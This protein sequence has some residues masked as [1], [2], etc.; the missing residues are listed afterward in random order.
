MSCS[1]VNSAPFQAT[2]FLHEQYSGEAVQILVVKG[3]W[4][5]SSGHFTP[6]H[7]QAPINV[8]DETVKLE[9]LDLEP[10]QRQAIAGREADTWLRYESDLIPP[11]PRF[12]L[13]INA[14]VQNRNQ[15][16]LKMPFTVN[17]NDQQLVHWVALAPRIWSHGVLGPVI[18]DATTLVSKVPAFNV[19]AFGGPA[20]RTTTPVPHEREPVETDTW[21]ANQDGMGYCTDAIRA[22]G[23]A[24]PWLEAPNHLISQWRNRP[25]PAALGHISRADSPRCISRGTS[26]GNKGKPPTDFDP[27]SLNAAPPSLQLM[28]LPTPGDRVRLLNLNRS[29]ECTFKFPQ[30]T[31]SAMGES[32]TGKRLPPV[33]LRWDTLLLEPEE[34]RASI[35]WRAAVGDP[36]GSLACITLTAECGR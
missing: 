7:L 25:L 34:D 29:G 1:I 19:F 36:G 6:P 32:R 30:L 28:R 26:G 31:L 18:K 2:T 5:L 33:Q 23:V 13:I 14:W 8:N 27:V 16:F 11:K 4:F 22:A 24:L 15:R 3:T 35:V 12:D 10:V 17:F 21:P 9:D 20:N